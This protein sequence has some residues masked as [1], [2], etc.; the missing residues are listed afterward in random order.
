MVQKLPYQ[1]IIQ[2]R[3]FDV[4]NSKESFQCPEKSYIGFKIQSYFGIKPSSSNP[5]QCEGNGHF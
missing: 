3:T 5:N 4:E 1:S 2:F